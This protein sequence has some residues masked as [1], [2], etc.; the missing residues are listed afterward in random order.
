MKKYLSRRKKK[1]ILTALALGFWLLTP[2]HRAEAVTSYTTPNGLFRLDY[3]G[4]GE[5]FTGKWYE[6][7]MIDYGE[8]APVEFERDK[9]YMTSQGELP[10][11]QKE[12]LNFAADYCEALLKH[13]KTAKQPVTLAVTVNNDL[14]NAAAEGSYTD[15]KINGQTVSVP[16]SNAVLNHGKVLTGE[17]GPAGFVVIGA[18]LFPPDG[19]QDRY[20]MPL[21]QNSKITF[22]STMIHEFGHALGI[23]T[24]DAPLTRFSEKSYRYESHLYDWRGV[25]AQPGIEIRTPNREAATEPYF[26]LPRYFDD[27]PDAAVPYFSGSHVRDVLEGAG[28]NT[29]NVFGYKLE[30]KVPGLPI[31]GNQGYDGE[32][33]V[34]LTHIELRN[35][36]MSHQMWR[37]YMS[38]MEAELALLQDLGYT[39][40]RR[41]FFG[42]SVYG[43][44]RTIVNDAPYYA[45]NADGTAYIAGTYNKNPYGMGLH[46][47]GSGNTVIQN[48]P[49]MTKGM[50]AVGIRID[51]CGNDVTVNKGVNVQA[52]GPNGNGI[53]AAYGKDHRITLAEGS[54]VTAE[55]EGGI[56]AAFDF[57]QN[58]Y[59]NEESAR[60]SYASRYLSHYFYPYELYPYDFKMNSAL[61]E[62]DGPLATDFTVRGELSGKRAAIAISDNAFVKNIHIGTGAKL[63]GDIVSRWV[64]DD[65]KITTV[66]YG[67]TVPDPDMAR[68][69]DGNDELTT[70]LSFEGT[71]LTY[72]GNIT[73][74]DNMRLNVSG[75]LLYGGTA[76]VLSAAVEKGGSLLGGTYDLIPDGAVRNASPNLGY[77]LPY[78]INGSSKKLQNVGLF[79]NHGTIGAAMKNAKLR[80]NGDLLSDG[81]LL[82]WAGGGAGHI[83]VSGRAKIDGSDVQVANWSDVLPDEKVTVLKAAS[84]EGDTKTP[85]GTSYA[86]SGMMSAENKIENNVLSVVTR[87]ENNLGAM[88]E[89]QR[90]TFDAMTT[91]YNNLKK[92]NDARINEMRTLFHL[93]PS[94]AKEALRSI[95][96]NA[97]AKNLAAVQRSNVTQHLLSARLNEAFTIKPVKVKIPVQHLDESNDD[98]VEI[99]AKTVEPAANDIWLK[100]GKNWGDVRGDTDYHSSAT[101]MGWDKA[102]GKNWRAGVFA[103]YGQT[104]FSD[105]TSSDRLKDTRFGLYAGFNKAKSEGMVYLDY[106]WLRNKLRRGVMGRTASAD[107]H[108]RILELGG[109]YLYDLQAG[110]NKAWHVRPYVNAQL[111][112]LWQNGYSETGAG[113][114]NQVVQSKHNDYFGMGAGVEFKRYLAGGNYAIRAGVK[115]AFAGAE[116][117]LRYSYMGDAANTYDMRN[118]QDK[119]HFVLSIGGEVEV[120]KGWSVGGDATWQRGRHDKDL[121]C[122]VTVRK[123]W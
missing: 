76:K 55:G 48:A 43:D 3:Y 83:A 40:D 104:S 28:M 72:N 18:P 2:W 73:G 5:S 77:S 103:G 24:S 86:V 80:I 33:Y 89:A 52:D 98:G 102:V 44:G 117:R 120:A 20:D 94:A 110:Q 57:G 88:D 93:S 6:D 65:D 16:T 54:K 37:N 19:E 91:M 60:A 11:W 47:Y 109:E 116:P 26:D 56:G 68:Q 67:E 99:T 30:Q 105:N 29:Y 63:S 70:R 78:K 10:D 115:H 35:S 42:R 46:I 81:T 50:A 12:Q 17:D 90:E 92:N 41:D 123:M 49:L 9:R 107:Y 36:V 61:L 100:F 113:V 27:W 51:G 87:T 75:G 8:D 69:Y 112:R 38:F 58:G 118:V 79:T 53:L 62:I 15:V 84:I 106:G 85:V 13:T 21:P 119:T 82:A 111:S 39:I 64:Y 74:A 34:D 59:G 71:G 122:S 31:N 95:S 96:S 66:I 1:T 25:Q 4:T 45:R 22:S 32:D 121:S 14:Y 97:S 7:N 101:L 114:F 108:S 23:W